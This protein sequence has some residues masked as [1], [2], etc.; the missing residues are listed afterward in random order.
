MLLPKTAHFA[1]GLRCDTITKNVYLGAAAMEYIMQR[2]QDGNTCGAFVLAY[3]QWEK[4][5]CETVQEEAG[6]AYVEQLYREIVFGS[7]M[8]GF[9]TYS[10]PVLM[11][12]WLA[13]QG[14]R[15]VFYLGEN[16]LVQKMFAVLQASAGA[17][18][19]ALQEAGMLCREALD[20]CRA[21][22]Y[23]VLV[24]QMEEDGAPAAKLHYVLMKKA[25]GGMPLIVNP[26]H[27]QARP[28]ARWPQ[29]GALLEPGLLWTGAA[30][31]I[32]DA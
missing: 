9:E 13:Q 29:P 26:W 30:I 3:Y 25:G 7:T 18:I 17:E 32:L 2:K 31:G 15:P 1:P 16:P 24:C 20:V 11:M 4:T 12:R 14:A 23:S 10:N 22:E 8:P 5:G 19:A 28:A 27:G 21:G 6:R